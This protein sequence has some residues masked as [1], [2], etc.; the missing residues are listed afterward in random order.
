VD[1]GTIVLVVGFIIVVGVYALNITRVDMGMEDNSLKYAYTRQARQIA[2]SGVHLAM[3]ALRDPNWMAGYQNDSL[4]GGSLYVS[5]DS[6]GLPSQYRRI[7]SEGRYLGNKHR[8][9][10]VIYAPSIAEETTFDL[11]LLTVR[12]LVE[13]QGSGI[14]IQPNKKFFINGEDTPLN[15]KHGIGAGSGLTQAIVTNALNSAGARDSVIGLPGNPNPKPSVA[16]TLS[17]T[18][19]MSRLDSAIRRVVTIIHAKGKLERKRTWGTISSP[20]IV[21]A[22]KSLTVDKSLAGAGILYINGSLTVEDSVTWNGYLIVHGDK[23]EVR[24]NRVVNLNGAVF[25]GKTGSSLRFGSDGKMRIKYSSSILQSLN[26]TLFGVTPR[27]KPQIFGGIYES[28]VYDTSG[29]SP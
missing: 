13:M 22:T 23:I 11:N 19:S 5:V 18:A 28:G 29:V 7:T 1:K 25:F 6:S 17:E 20:E 16:P 24:S 10:A 14:N 26:S 15:T 21:Y 27:E 12:A 9:V 8:V 4:L 2:L 3:N